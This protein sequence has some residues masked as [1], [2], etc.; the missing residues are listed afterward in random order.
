VL[1]RVM[2]QHWISCT[3]RF[4]SSARTFVWSEPG[5]TVVIRSDPTQWAPSFTDLL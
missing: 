3:D 2:K 1:Q 5:C 4:W